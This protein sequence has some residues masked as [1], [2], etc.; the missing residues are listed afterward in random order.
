MGAKNSDLAQYMSDELNKS[1]TDLSKL[2]A[3]EL[4][5]GA[6]S[7]KGKDIKAASK[8]MLDTQESKR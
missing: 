3:S 2:M 4:R 7:A 6:D 8:Q 1:G 5:K